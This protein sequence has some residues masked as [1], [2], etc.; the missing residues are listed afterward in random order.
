MRACM[1]MRIGF[2]KY[3]QTTVRFVN[4]RGI[5]DA[6]G[7]ASVPYCELAAFRNHP[8]M[9]TTQTQTLERWDET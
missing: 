4:G 5:C 7:Y 2:S 6:A 8:V 9:M 3:L 1:M